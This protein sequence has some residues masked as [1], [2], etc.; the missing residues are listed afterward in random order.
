MTP[1]FNS[2]PTPLGGELSVR[3]N[4]RDAGGHSDSFRRLR[5]KVGG[6]DGFLRE[7][8]LEATGAGSFGAKIPLSR[9][10]AYLATVIDETSGEPLATTGAALAAGE[11]LRPT[12]SD[13][14]LLSRLALV[15][16]GKTR[17]TLA[18]IFRDRDQQRRAYQGLDVWWFVLGAGALIASVG[19]R[20][21]S[22]S[23]PGFL[24]R[25]QAAPLEPSPA[26]GAA[27]GGTLAALRTVRQRSERG[28][29][30]PPSVLPPLAPTAARERATKPRS[31]APKT[32]SAAEILLER[33]RRRERGG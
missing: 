31:A 8:A 23:L 18:G 16:G 9:P 6:P 32:Q 22:L 15:T 17:S 14:A 11:E 13:R 25:R 27:L 10:G 12:G 7:L 21:L 1:E 20:R 2:K 4:A 33:R 28:S 5:V 29:A 30:G 19:A 24:R 26:A 3:V